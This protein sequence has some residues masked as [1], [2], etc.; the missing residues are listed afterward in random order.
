MSLRCRCLIFALCL[1]PVLSCYRSPRPIGVKLRKR[2]QFESEWK[3]YLKLSPFKS[4][5]VAGD[6]N[7]VYVSGFAHDAATQELADEEALQHCEQRRRDR[8]IDDPCRTYAV[9]EDKVAPP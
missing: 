5:A 4:L 7:G 3:A 2:T 8:R 6:L 1:L 9:G